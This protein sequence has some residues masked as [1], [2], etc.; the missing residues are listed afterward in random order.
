MSAIK[1]LVNDGEGGRVEI[2]AEL[3]ENRKTTVLVRLPDGTVIT[4]KKTRDLPKEACDV[5]A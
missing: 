2:V 3:I 1:V 4:R 5:K